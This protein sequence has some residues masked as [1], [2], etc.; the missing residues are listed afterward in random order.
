MTL[1]FMGI[2]AWQ[3]P[4][5]VSPSLPGFQLAIFGSPVLF[6]ILPCVRLGHWPHWHPCVANLLMEAVGQTLRDHQ[7]QRLWVAVP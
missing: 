5:A 1:S 4:A 3:P 7:S 2:K 6:S